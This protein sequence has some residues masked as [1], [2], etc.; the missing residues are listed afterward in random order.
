MSVF[1]LTIFTLSVIFTV[2]C[3]L[4]SDKRFL[5]VERFL[6]SVMFSAVIFSSLASLLN[7]DGF[8]SLLPEENT[9]EEHLFDEVILS[10]LARGLEEALIEEFSLRREDFTLT[11]SDIDE[12]THLPR[13]VVV[14]LENKGIFQDTRRMEEYLKEKG[15]FRYVRVNLRLGA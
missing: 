10:S 14:T 4:V 12:S 7:G 11:L 9:A 5:R 2:A 1:L 15:G 13:A 6:F 3:A 8:L